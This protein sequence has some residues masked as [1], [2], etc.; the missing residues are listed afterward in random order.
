MYNLERTITPPPPREKK[1]GVDR[2]YNIILSGHNI[3]VESWFVIYLAY[4]FLILKLAIIDRPGYPN[5]TP[6]LLV[7]MLY[8]NVIA[9]VMTTRMC[10]LETSLV[11]YLSMM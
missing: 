11:V 6:R 1:G 3:G 2:L 4:F 8:Y 7:Y 5:S 9:G 10:H